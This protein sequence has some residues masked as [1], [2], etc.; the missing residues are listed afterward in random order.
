MVVGV[1]AGL[2]LAR[3]P[4]HHALSQ[5]TRSQKMYHGQLSCKGYS[6]LLGS[7]KLARGIGIFLITN[8]P[9]S[10]KLLG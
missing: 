1:W 2:L 4:N 8:Y 7:R 6:K 9:I 3:P 5:Q 10:Q